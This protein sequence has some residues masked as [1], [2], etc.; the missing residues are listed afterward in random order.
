MFIGLFVPLSYA[1]VE[2]YNPILT[3]ARKGFSVTLN[4]EQYEYMKGPQTEAG[5]KVSEV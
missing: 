4:V 3:G 1:Y 5:V 2:L